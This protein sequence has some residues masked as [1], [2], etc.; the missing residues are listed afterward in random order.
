MAQKEQQT[1][2]HCK[3]IRDT[4]RK[5]KKSTKTHSSSSSSSSRNKRS[6]GVKEEKKD[7]KKKRLSNDN[8]CHIHWSSHKWGSVIKTKVVTTSN[9]GDNQQPTLQV[10]F[11]IIRATLQTPLCP[12]IIT[13]DKCKSITMM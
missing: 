4:N 11:C 3:K 10:P 5:N 9:L 2:A 1:D 12:H 13:Q 6:S 8:D 7:I